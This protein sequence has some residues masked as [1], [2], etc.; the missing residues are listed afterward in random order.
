[1]MEMVDKR[2]CWTASLLVAFGMLVLGCP[3]R[4]LQD[5]ADLR[6]DDVERQDGPGPAVDRKPASGRWTSMDYGGDRVLRRVWGT[7]AHDVF[8]VGDLGIILHYDGVAWS[9][10]IQ[11]GAFSLLGAVGL[12]QLQCV[13]G[14]RE[15]SDLLQALS[16][17]LVARACFRSGLPVANQLPDDGCHLTAVQ[18]LLLQLDPLFQRIAALLVDA[19]MHAPASHSFSTTWITSRVW[20]ASGK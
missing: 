20:A 9:T 10:M 15:G 13:R 1:M 5:D 2:C 8:V 4:T 3:G 12:Q 19:R 14:G 16:L 11:G 7:S 17:A 18:A 6:Q